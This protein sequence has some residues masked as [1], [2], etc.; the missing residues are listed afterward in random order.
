MKWPVVAIREVAHVNPKMCSSDRR[1]SGELVSFVP[2]AAISEH[3]AS[4][5]LEEDRTLSDVS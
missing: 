4:I 1:D 3:T 2:M 5:K